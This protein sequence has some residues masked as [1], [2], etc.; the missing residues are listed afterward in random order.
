MGDEISKMVKSCVSCAQ[1]KAGFKDPA[2]ELHPLPIRGLGYRWGVDFTRPMPTTKSSNKYVLVMIEHFTKRVELVPLPNKTADLTRAT[3]LES[4]L[5]RFGAPAKVV[6][7]QES[8]FKG[9]FFDLLHHHGIDHRMD[10]REHSQADGLS[11]RM[12]HTINRGLKK[13]MSEGAASDWDLLL[14]YVSMG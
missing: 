2:V 1:V 9:E 11:E 13:S 3:F 14:P 6:T 7:D 5:S 4:V 10:S 12:V 8:E